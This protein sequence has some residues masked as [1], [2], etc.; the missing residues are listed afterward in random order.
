M[1]E[2]PALQPC[3]PRRHSVAYFFAHRSRHRRVFGALRARFPRYIIEARHLGRLA[4]TEHVPTAWIYDGHGV[5]GLWRRRPT[6]AKGLGMASRTSVRLCVRAT[7]RD[8]RSDCSTRRHTVSCA[9]IEGGPRPRYRQ[10]G[11]PV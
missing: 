11:A 8:D 1:A 9:F 3:T 6:M 5:V 4:S 10:H 2:V 7:R